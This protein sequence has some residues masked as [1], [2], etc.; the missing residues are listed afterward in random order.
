MREKINKQVNWRGKIPY[1][2]CG[3]QLGHPG[4]D[5][6]RNDMPAGQPCEWRTS[7]EVKYVHRTVWITIGR[8]NATSCSDTC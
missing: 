2:E 5:P 1:S 8:W 6:Q 3:K 4:E 7:L